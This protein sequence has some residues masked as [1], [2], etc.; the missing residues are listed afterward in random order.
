M[1]CGHESN[2][3][4]HP[5][6][7]D[8]YFHTITV[9]LAGGRLDFSSLYVPTFIKGLSVS[10]RT[11]QAPTENYC[12]YATADAVSWGWQSCASLT[13]FEG[14]STNTVPFIKLEGFMGAP[15]P[16]LDKQFHFSRRELAYQLES[17][18]IPEDY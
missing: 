10:C 9:A 3:L 7:L 11:I 14:V 2:Y 1:P 5:V 15:L 4:I 12:C 6:L 13:V 18:P 16:K 17:R 8:T